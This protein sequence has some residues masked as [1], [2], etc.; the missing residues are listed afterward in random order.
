VFF[1]RS[2]VGGTDQCLGWQNAGCRTPRYPFRPDKF[3][4]RIAIFIGHLF[5]L[6]RRVARH[7]GVYS[8]RQAQIGGLCDDLAR[9]VNT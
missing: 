5:P 6:R 4:D 1:Q 8:T 9:N 7:G 2:A 3:G